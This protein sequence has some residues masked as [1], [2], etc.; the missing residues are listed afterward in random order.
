M[1]TVEQE[2]VLRELAESHRGRSFWD[3][4]SAVTNGIQ[5]RMSSSGRLGV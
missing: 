1:P 2:N 5:R 4:A 3:V